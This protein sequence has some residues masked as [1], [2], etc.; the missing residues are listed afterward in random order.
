MPEKSNSYIGLYSIGASDELWA[1]IQNTGNNT[2]GNVL[3]DMPMIPG[4]YQ[5]KIGYF[6]NGHM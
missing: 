1:D 2:T 3:F 5:F 4:V 6:A